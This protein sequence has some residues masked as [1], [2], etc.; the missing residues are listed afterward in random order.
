MIEWISFLM[1]LATLYVKT[2][3]TYKVEFLMILPYVLIVYWA[4]SKVFTDDDEPPVMILLWWLAGG[5]GLTAIRCFSAGSLDIP[6]LL[7]PFKV[8]K[9]GLQSATAFIVY[10][11]I[12]YLISLMVPKKKG[13]QWYA[14][15]FPVIG[16]MMV[17]YF[18]TDIILLLIFGL[19][20]LIPVWLILS[21]LPYVGKGEVGEEEEL[22][23]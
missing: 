21:F 13:Y 20:G 23:E 16:L 8:P 19:G 1:G 10:V 11:L 5:G 7:L 12:F 4:V 14:R 2:L 22:F 15:L 17:P 9:L 18:N 6:P 3:M